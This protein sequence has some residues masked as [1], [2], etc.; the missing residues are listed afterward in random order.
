[1][2]FQVKSIGRQKSLY[3][4]MAFFMFSAQAVDNKTLEILQLLKDKKYT[5]AVPL[6]EKQVRQVKELKKKGYYSFLLNQL[7]ADVK[8]KK[9][10]HEYA[11]IAGQYAPDIS[12]RKKLLLWME[13]GD[14]F[15]K[16]GNLKK[17]SYC[18]QKA[19][20]Y[21]HLGGPEKPYIL[22]KQAWIY[23]NQ[24]KWDKAYALLRQAITEKAQKLKVLILFDMGKIWVES[25]YFK[26]KIP[27]SA[28]AKEIKVLSIDEKKSLIQGMAQG[29]RRV[30]K[31]S[32]EPLVSTLSD[33]KTLST[34]I[35]NDLLSTP[36]WPVRSACQLIPWVESTNTSSIN[37]KAVF[38]VLNSCTRYWISK[39]KNPNRSRQ[40]KRIASLYTQFE[41][42]GM[43]RWPLSLSYHHLRWHNK[44][45]TESLYQLTELLNQTGLLK[46]AALGGFLSS[47]VD[48]K[49]KNSKK[50]SIPSAKEHGSYIETS[51]KESGRFCK[52]AKKP[53]KSLVLK[54]AQ[55]LL[56][57]PYLSAKYKNREGDYESTLFN[58][59]KL[60]VFSSS[61]KPFILTAH[62]NWKGKDFLPLLLLP[63][64][65]S[66][67]KKELKAFMDRFS[68]R[69]LDLYY[70]NI[71]IERQDILTEEN[72][73]KWIP[74]ADIKS[75]AQSKPYYSSFSVRPFN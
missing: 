38:S 41:R 65:N 52:K 1:M 71:L 24:K 50:P 35:L 57:D 73:N 69:P 14:G 59:F 43:E 54:T 37:K 7:P 61:L 4:C 18:Y 62:E 23:I 13:A 17:A 56:A 3:L 33:D 29:V 20:S 67:Q 2:N 74:L 10:R 45:C 30:E 28:L 34:A 19:L 51:L 36:L 12:Q 31:Q 26:N 63:N 68:A 11:F 6:L 49:H 27:V 66:Y 47:K 32:F 58:F 60:K 48:K 46:G 70:L 75:Y 40:L 5:V 39:K 44:A 22:H 21:T 8:M 72:L 9:P 53:D 25:Q 55:T 42:K 64:I 16:T 15:F